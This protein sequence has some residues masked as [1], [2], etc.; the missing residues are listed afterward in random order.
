MAK[1]KRTKPC[2]NCKKSKVKCIYSNN[3][4]CERCVKIGQA[5]NC[6][7][8][9]KLPSLKLPLIS[10]Q[11]QAIRPAQDDIRLPPLNSFT[12]HI[13]LPAS[14]HHQ[15]NA[16][17]SDKLPQR[18]NAMTAAN[19]VAGNPQ[20]LQNPTVNNLAQ[21]PIS[22][23]IPQYMVQHVPQP[24]MSVLP[25]EDISESDQH[26]KTQM[27]NKING[28]DNKLNDL[29]DILKSNQRFLMENQ[30]RYGQ[31]QLQYPTSYPPQKGPLD[32]HGHS[33]SHANASHIAHYDSLPSSRPYSPD[34]TNESVPSQYYNR[35]QYSQHYPSHSLPSNDFPN[36]KRRHSHYVE[37]SKKRPK[38]IDSDRESD[39][40]KRDINYPKDFR[41]GF[42]DKSQAKELFKFFDTNISPQLFGF[43]IS[44]FL[45]DSIWES[46]PILICAICTIASM[47]HPDQ[48][49]SSKLY[50]LQEYL[51]ISCSELLYKGRPVNELDGFNTIMAL[52]LCSFWLSNAQMFTGLALQIAKEIG[53]TDSVTNHNYKKSGGL[54]KRDRLKL[55]YLLYVLDG[56]Q[57]L[58]FNRQRLVSSDEYSLKH[59]KSILIN[60]NLT[61]LTH[62]ERS[63]SQI[64]NGDTEGTNN[65]NEDSKNQLE[66]SVVTINKEVSSQKLTDM[67]LVSQVEYNQ[68]LNEAFRGEAWDLLAPS[69]LGIPSKS[70]L[71]LDRWMVSWAVLLSPVN[72]G[73]VW[74]SKSTLIY[75]NFA[76]MHINSAAVRQL[77]MD[78]GDE[79]RVILP[80]WNNS[81]SNG[82]VR[83]NS[84]V[85]LGKKFK[86]IKSTNEEDSDDSSDSD[87]DF[88]SNHELISDNEAIVSA[89]IAVTAAQTV[90]NLVLNDKDILN[91]LKYV[92]VHIHIMLYYAALLLI[93]PPVESANKDAESKSTYLFKMVNNLKIVKML[94][95]KIYLNCPTD[96]SFGDRLIRSLD[97]LSQEKLTKLKDE[98]N[99]IG[100]DEPLDPETKSQLFR[101]L[102]EITEALYS[103]NITE[104]NN[105][106][107]D[108]SSRGSS[109]GPEKISAWPGSNHG[110]P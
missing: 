47:H 67:R 110:H 68:A 92:P 94:Q 53:L 76:K 74:S 32:T 10:P 45:V 51:H 81:T 11:P 37:D 88:V 25:N 7:F 84:K 103:E 107:V 99:D 39:D 95:R 28:F 70:N 105:S 9:P 46:S 101:Q 14:H 41:D 58:T 40:D 91:N 12:N 56:Q 35:E 77:K 5:V 27:E 21:N 104:L 80:R 66:D 31:P 71:E 8:V 55:W 90:L 87:E 43:E 109:P 89:N 30:Q 23:A 42:L 59:S 29:V 85:H 18:P 96:K 22:N 1:E 82:P 6:Q 106:S 16:T 19:K 98:I 78:T 69:S 17:S 24:N 57:S 3:L 63:P 79:N 48:T 50:K 26:W 33:S 60:D 49:L 38:F 75:Y 100:S 34:P 93:N 102:S 36:T 2:S 4:P 54:S 15:A 73:A 62:M 52:I 86:N 61:S 97:D 108:G 83:A 20:P 44:R 13:Q 65:K 64:E 72:N